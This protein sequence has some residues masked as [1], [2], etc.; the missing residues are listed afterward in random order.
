MCGVAGPLGLRVRANLIPPHL[1]APQTV[2]LASSGH[3]EAPVRPEQGQSHGHRGGAEEEGCATP[4]S[5]G[6]PDTRLRVSLHTQALPAGCW[7]RAPWDWLGHQQHT[8]P[9]ARSGPWGQVGGNGRGGCSS[10]ALG[11]AAPALGDK[12]EELS[13]EGRLV[14]AGGRAPRA[15]PHR[16]QF[17]AIP[18][19]LGGRAGSTELQERGQGA[20]APWDWL[21][22]QQ[23]TGPLAR[24]RPW[25][26]VRGNGRGGVAL[27]LWGRPPPQ[28]GGALAQTL[29]P[30]VP[31]SQARCHV[32]SCSQR[33]NRGKMC[34][35]PGA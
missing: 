4:W 30:R 14:G 15:V 9:L 17:K 34:G 25:G 2:G 20:R 3:G 33:G 29:A 23:H 6:R 21:G 24:S 16:L 11:T 7:S 22:H 12:Q 5:W 26:Q 1:P 18:L 27:L 8:G 28:V 10:V 32:T 13:G 19:R 35:L 31:G